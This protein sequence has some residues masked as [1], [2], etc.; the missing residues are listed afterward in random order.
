MIAQYLALNHPD[1][2]EKLVLN[3]TT[4]ETN[5][6][7][8]ANVDHWVDFARQDRL[9]DI[10]EEMMGMMYP[11]GKEPTE[12]VYADLV[13]E[14]LL[15]HTPE[16][17]ATMAEAC[18]TCSTSD[19][20]HEIKCPVLVLGGG[21][22]VIMSGEASVDLANKL[23][24]EAVIFDDLGHGAYEAEEYQQRVLDFLEK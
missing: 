5:P 24:T 13:P 21:V 10:S 23:G 15:K 20:L 7:L 2:V 9:A 4:A 18:L 17:F 14:E 6:V 19:R 11:P 12:D 8:K 1:L 22:D 3:V 16:E